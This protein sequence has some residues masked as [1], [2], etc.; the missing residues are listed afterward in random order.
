[1]K[2][3]ALLKTCIICLPRWVLYTVAIKSLFYLQAI[4]HVYLMRVG[5]VRSKQS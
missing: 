3:H 1:L 2:K 4:C 5:R